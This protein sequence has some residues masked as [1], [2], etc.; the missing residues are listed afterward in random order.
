[1]ARSVKCLTLDLGS[2]HDLRVRETEP[3]SG[4]A[5]TALCLLGILCLSLSAPPPQKESHLFDCITVHPA[6]FCVISE[7]V[8]TAERWFWNSRQNF[9]QAVGEVLP[10]V[11]LLIS[12]MPFP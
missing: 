9:S 3:P 6:V 7:N 5:L 4:S 12:L 1:M 10:F 8:S 11:K 2:G